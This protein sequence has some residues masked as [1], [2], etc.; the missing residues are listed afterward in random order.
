MNIIVPCMTFS[1]EKG[2]NTVIYK[3][4]V[5]SCITCLATHPTNE[6]LITAGLYNGIPKYLQKKNLNYF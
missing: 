5:T 1:L 2:R 4:E 3:L 6:N